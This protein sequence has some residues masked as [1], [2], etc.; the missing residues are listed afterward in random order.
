M[1]ITNS[2]KSFHKSVVNSFV[3]RRFHPYSSWLPVLSAI[4][5][6]CHVQ[7]IVGSEAIKSKTFG[8]FGRTFA[9][10]EENFKTPDG[11]NFDIELSVNIDDFCKGIVVILHGLES[12]IKGPLVNKMASAFISSGFGCCLV[13]F[14]GCNGIENQRPGGYHLGFTK[15]L[16]QVISILNTRYSNIPIYISGKVYFVF[17]V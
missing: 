9:T 17:I 7:T 14:R 15:D 3:A 16:N 10:I 13:S 1:S 8:A 6:N 4:C 2:S 5:S 11:D 12:N